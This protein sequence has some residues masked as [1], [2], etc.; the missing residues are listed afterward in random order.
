VKVLKCFKWENVTFLK[1]F[2]KADR[3]GV[4]SQQGHGTVDGSFGKS[5]QRYLENI[6]NIKV[7]AFVA[8][9]V[10]VHVAAI[11]H[12]LRILRLK[13]N[14][15]PPV[16]DG[17]V[18][19]VNQGI[20]GQ[21]L[22]IL[23]IRIIVWREDVGQLVIGT[24]ITAYADYF[25]AL[26]QVARRIDGRHLIAAINGWISMGVIKYKWIRHTVDELWRFIY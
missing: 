6:T 10:A 4:L 25:A 24:A 2:T 26:A 13:H 23:I 5:F 7:H 20:A 14:T 22:E 9:L 12:Y 8:W 17:H 18:H 11:P 3:S 1:R 16:K 19:F 15:T 21:W